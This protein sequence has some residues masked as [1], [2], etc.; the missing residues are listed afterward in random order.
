[1]EKLHPGNSRRVLYFT[2]KILVDQF[3]FNI[4]TT[5]NPIKTVLGND[6]RENY[7]S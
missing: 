6:W 1:M 7:P 5:N 2:V 4:S 3:K